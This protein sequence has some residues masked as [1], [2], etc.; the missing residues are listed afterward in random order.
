MGLQPHPNMADLDDI[1]ILGENGK[2]RIQKKHRAILTYKTHIAK[3]T[4]KK[5]IIA[6]VGDLLEIYIAHEL[7]KAK[8][9]TG[10]PYLHTHVVFW[11]EKPFSTENARFFDLLQIH[12]H[13]RII[14][15]DKS[16]A[17]KLAWIRAVR[18]L[19]KEDPDN[20]HLKDFMQDEW[21]L[22]SKTMETKV[23]EIQAAKTL[24][25]AYSCGERLSEALAI[26]TIFESRVN[27]RAVRRKVPSPWSWQAD[28]LDKCAVFREDCRIVTWYYDPIGGCGKS[29][30]I[31]LAESRFGPE[32]LFVS[33]SGRVTDMAEVVRTHI[34]RTST[35]P[36]IIFVDLERSVRDRDSIY[37][38]IENLANGRLTATKYSSESF[39]VETDHLVVFS[40]FLPR[41]ERLS[42]DRWN[43][44]HLSKVK[45]FVTVSPIDA[46]SL[47]EEQLNSP[48]LVE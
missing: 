4:L 31:D 47:L 22:L 10:E 36:R 27:Q 26:K 20:A 14:N 39:K 1:P 32:F 42:L 46:N 29:T 5:W 15:M 9:E 38:V 23:A 19:A 44:L 24:N 45:D 41:V 7:G 34:K 43:I 3:D 48:I 33:S 25:E 40:N 17:T 12:P 11:S 18:Y 28:L 13:C 37:S 8:L 35:D 21:L 6:C 30:C 16:K 2:F